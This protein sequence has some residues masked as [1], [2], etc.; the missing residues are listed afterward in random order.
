MV[1]YNRKTNKKPKTNR[2]PKTNKKIRIKT[3]KKTNRKTNRKTFKKINRKN[4][5]KI[6][7]RL[8]KKSLRKSKKVKRKMN[9]KQRGGNFFNFHK[10]NTMLPISRNGVSPSGVHSPNNSNIILESKLGQ[11]GG[12]TNL[13]FSDNALNLGEASMKQIL[14]LK[15]QFLG[16]DLTQTNPYPFIQNKM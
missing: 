10:S 5:K 13:G 2:K 14:T 12:F 1:N 8:S 6:N 11:K 15:D 16:N 4:Y 3:N 9:K 7:K